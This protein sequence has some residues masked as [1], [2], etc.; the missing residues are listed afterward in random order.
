MTLDLSSLGWDE[1]F[2]AAFA[3]HARPDQEP[4]RVTRVDRGVCTLL[5][6]D[7]TRRASIGGSVL[8]TAAV[9]PTRL[10]CAG[11][12]VVLRTWPDARV[13]IEA[14]LPRRTAVVRAAAGTESVAQT[15]VANVDSVAV[16]VA[17]DPEPDIGLVE[18][19][20]ALAWESGAQPI[21]ALTKVD[22]MA[23]PQALVEEI[24]EIAPNVEV[25]GVSATTGA[26]VDRLRELITGGRT[27]GLLGASGSGKSTL[28]NALAG[29][30]VMATQAIRRRDGRG[31]HTTTHRALVA[32]PGGG[33]VVDIPGIRAAGLYAGTDGLDQAFADIAELAATC[34]FDDCGHTGEPG[35]AVLAALA[36]GELSQRRMDHWRKLHREIDRETSRR[37]QRIAEHE[38]RRWAAGRARPYPRSS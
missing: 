10:P 8:A 32:L 4:A 7:G 12:W 18:R 22:L 23:H 21:V 19:L 30:T 24:R 11:D 13:T 20:L 16:I 33:A 26:G 29:A 3:R 31:R 1:S 6:A 36:A 37:D 5:A 27:L 14:I 34:R 15:L 17:V 38:R 2:R 9:D 35:C 28:V 25:V